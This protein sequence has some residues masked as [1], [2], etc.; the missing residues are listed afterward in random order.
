MNP[1][2]EAVEARLAEEAPS[3]VYSDELA[4]ELGLHEHEAEALLRKLARSSDHIEVS[5]AGQ[6]FAVSVSKT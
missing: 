6:G 5:P 2:V 1:L 4:L 3:I